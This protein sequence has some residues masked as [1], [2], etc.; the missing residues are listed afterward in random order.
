M[1]ALRDEHESVLQ[2]I[3]AL[4]LTMIDSSRY[5]ENH[6]MSLG[7]ERGGR[8]GGASKDQRTKDTRSGMIV[9]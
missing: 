9:A 2:G 7:C 1:S 4:R 6:E 3:R 8:R 5:A